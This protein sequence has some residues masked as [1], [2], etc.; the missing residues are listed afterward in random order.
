MHNSQLSDLSMDEGQPWGA[1]INVGP[2][3]W[4]PFLDSQSVDPS[5]DG[6]YM[7]GASVGFG[8]GEWRQF[9]DTMQQENDV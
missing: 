6:G 5:P 7:W 3:E 8:L 1:L 2:G 9:L 4:G